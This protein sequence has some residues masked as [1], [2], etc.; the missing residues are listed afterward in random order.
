[1]RA[2]APPRT[3]SAAAPSTGAEHRAA[4]RPDVL[5][6]G[7]IRVMHVVFA[8]QPGGMEFGVVKLVNGLAGTRIR[9][10]IC[11]T[12]AAGDM[13]TLL[14]PSVRLFELRRREGN[15]PR[16]VWE[17]CKLFRRERPHIVHTHAWGTLLEGLIAAR[18]ARVPAVVHG[19][20]GT[21][22]LRGYQRRIQCWA[23]GRANQLLSVS[24]MLSDRMA[25][26]TG[27]PIRRIRTIQNGVDLTRFQT[28]ARAD[29]RRVLGL[30][31][32]GCLI[33]TVGRLVPVKDQANL[34]EA[35]AILRAS[36]L[37]FTAVIAGD[38]PLRDDLDALAAARGLTGSVR[39]LGHRTDVERVY[40]ALDVFALT[41]KSEGMSNTILEAMAS[42]LPVVATHV[43]GAAELVDDSTGRLVPAEDA[44]AL[45]GALRELAADA[46]LRQRMGS[47]GRDKAERRFGVPRMVHEY[48]ALY[49]D[50]ARGLARR[51]TT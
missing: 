21:L 1:M 3:A 10:S 34:L 50:V 17:L 4:V 44:A 46:E 30:P 25:A 33:G 9:S 40:A 38:G 19:E 31:S 18:L 41:S 29:A 39:F 8:L 28:I 14:H 36:G 15:D 27:F 51:R 11:S 37:Q 13:R 12:A 7:P 42:G 35:L 6:E 2:F 43:G 49:L 48:H 45:A 24:Q 5:S 22:Q 26:T 16:L 23:W 32:D 20:H 47:A